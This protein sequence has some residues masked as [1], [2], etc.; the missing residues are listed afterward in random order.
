MP[1]EY[2]ILLW[3]A[4]LIG[5]VGL[6]AALAIVVTIG[7]AMDIRR[8]FKTLREEHARSTVENPEQKE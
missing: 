1:L 8:L 4:V 5:G 2:W 3:K 7:G 6:F